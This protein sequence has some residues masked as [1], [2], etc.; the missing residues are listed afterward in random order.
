MPP[1]NPFHGGVHCT[2]VRPRYIPKKACWKKGKEENFVP[3]VYFHFCPK[4]KEASTIYFFFFRPAAGKFWVSRPNSVWLFYALFPPTTP[5]SFRERNEM[6]SPLFFFCQESGSF[7][8]PLSAI[9]PPISTSPPLFSALP[10]RG[11]KSS[12]RHRRHKGG[13]E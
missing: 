7:L 4:E 13:G 9:F 3:F 11:D 6:A 12:L 10:A 1:P 8:R 5:S 2:Y